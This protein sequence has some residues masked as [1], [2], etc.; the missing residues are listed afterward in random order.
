MQ[1]YLQ[2]IQHCLYIP[3]FFHSHIYLELCGREKT[4]AKYFDHIPIIP[5][6]VR[7][8]RRTLQFYQAF[9]FWILHI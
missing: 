2:I 7:R 1:M 5:F 8:N 6:A 3:I 9:A 4:V